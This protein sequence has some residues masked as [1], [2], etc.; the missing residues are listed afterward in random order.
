MKGSPKFLI[1]F[2]IFY[3][4]RAFLLLFPVNIPTLADMSLLFHYF[5]FRGRVPAYIKDDVAHEVSN[6]NM[7]QVSALVVIPGVEVEFDRSAVTNIIP[8]AQPDKSLSAVPS[9]HI[10]SL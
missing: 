9:R 3:T 2:L 4:L 5:V 10:S 7:L 8:P 1:I 6:V